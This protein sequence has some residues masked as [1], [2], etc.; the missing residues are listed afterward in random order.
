MPPETPIRLAELLASISLAADLGNGFPPEKALRNT[1]IGMAIAD[2][3]G[4]DDTE[5]SNVLYA[6]LMRFLGCTSFSW[7]LSRWTG[8]EMATLHAF[9]PVDDRSPSEIVGALKK[10]GRG[11]GASTRARALF[12]NTVRGKTIGE[13]IVRVDCEANVRFSRRLG[14]SADIGRILNEQYERWDGKGAPQKLAGEAIHPG[15]RILTV[16]NQIE[17]FHREGGPD[18]ARAM[19]RRRTGG[20]FDPD[21]AAAFERCAGDVLPRLDEGTVWEMVLGAE[22]ERRVVIPASRLDDLAAAFADFADLKAPHLL[23]HS[24]GVARLAEAA[25]T[26]VGLPADEVGTLRRA[27]LLHDLGRVAVTNAIWGRRG[28]LSPPEWEQVRLH[29]YHTERVLSRAPALEPIGRLAGAHHERLDGSGYHRGAGAAGLSRA[30]RI[31]AAADVH[32]ALTEDRPHRPAFGADQAVE[33]METMVSAG[34]LD[35]EAVRAVCE[36]AGARRPA[37][38]AAY[39][40]GLTEREVDVLRLLARGKTKKEIA[41]TLFIA[42]GTVHTHV[43][44]IYDKIGSSSRAGAALFAMEHGLVRD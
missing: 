31:L 2:E 15:A 39:P 43:T 20:W 8:D 24:S 40:G 11:R 34:R 28:P 22:P 30:A 42:P 23:G 7:E 18:E 14:M 26:S 3:L 33:E 16:A 19:V 38:R 29:A 17:F 6:S 9:A 12:N 41:K 10:V 21:C 36:A 25:A 44:H 27:A 37:T 1:L 5:R 4:L 32:H 13:F 35:P